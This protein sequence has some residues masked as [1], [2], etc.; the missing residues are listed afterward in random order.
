MLG[1][2]PRPIDLFVETHALNKNRKKGKKLL[3]DN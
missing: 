2:V 1:Y 3:M